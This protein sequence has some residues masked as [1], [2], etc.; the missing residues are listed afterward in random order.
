MS[1]ALCFLPAPRADP[2]TCV[3][4]YV[5]RRRKL[6]RKLMINA[7]IEHKV[8]CLPST[9]CCLPV[10]RLTSAICL[11][12]V[13]LSDVWY[14]PICCLSICC[15]LVCLSDGHLSA[16][17]ILCLLSVVRTPIFAPPDTKSLISLS[18]RATRDIV[19]LNQALIIFTSLIS[20]SYRALSYSY[21]VVLNQAL[22]SFADPCVE[23]IIKY[24]NMT[25]L[26]IADVNHN[27]VMGDLVKR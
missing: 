11:S 6:S 13:C 5:V 4:R 17:P 22:I 9:V 15:P 26:D 2:A 21:I 18:Y 1:S 25:L 7:I 16:T 19:I 10:W 20:I 12:A 14:L 3:I 8:R 27:I 23:L 24:S